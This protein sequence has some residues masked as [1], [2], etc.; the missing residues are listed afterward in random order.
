MEA[1]NN[2]TEQGNQQPGVDYC[3]AI[4]HTPGGE[5][6]NTY[7]CNQKQ[8]SVADLWYIQKQRR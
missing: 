4:F 3:Q 5:V 1:N 6:I 7:K 8:L 2:Q